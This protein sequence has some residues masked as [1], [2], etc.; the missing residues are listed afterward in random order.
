[1]SLQKIKQWLLSLCDKWRIHSE[2]YAVISWIFLRC[3]ALIYFAAFASMSVQ[4]DGLIGANGILPLTTKLSAWA[5]HFPDNKYWL[6]PTLFWLDAA[7]FT[8]RLVCYSGMA[9]ALLLLLNF[10]TRISLIACYLLY[11]SIYTAG[12]TFTSFQ[13]D[14]FLLETGFLAIFLPWGSGIIIFLFR[15]LIARFMFMGGVVKL[16]SH[17]PSWANLTALNFHYQT[18]PLPSPLA[19]YAYYLPEWFHQLCV[20]GVFIIEL[21]VPFFVFLPRKFRLFAAWSFIALQFSIILTGNYGFFNLLTISLCL[22]LFD[23]SYIRRLI[24]NN[25]NQYIL[26]NWHIP[27]KKSTTFASLWACMVFLVCA[28]NIWTF[29]AKKYPDAPL[30]AI[31]H[32]TST[33]SLVNNYGPFA[34]MTTKRPE[35]I[36]EGSQNGEQWL[37]YRFHYK[38]GDLYKN[39][40]WNIPHQ[41]RL[42]WQMWFA[43]LQAPSKDFWF[44]QFLKKLQEGSAPVL[45]LLAHNPFPEA[46]P[47]Y[48]R[49]RLYQYFYTPK[50]VRALNG[51]IWQR[52]HI[53]EF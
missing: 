15:W 24:P 29:H 4:I 26:T 18:Q 13:W 36:V 42:D 51:Q 52:V 48:I 3:L 23:D 8:L 11:L 32:F 44:K 35:I 12:Q 1:L 37:Q 27:G 14:S 20:A 2:Q 47:K 41:P 22:F 16:A 6:F 19:Y 49:T 17:D 34:V 28:A 43:A 25:L 9:A 46:P 5:Q 38:P 10:F 31:M 39:L 30:K 7:D 40:S 53:G 33:F 21:I 45:R 50:E